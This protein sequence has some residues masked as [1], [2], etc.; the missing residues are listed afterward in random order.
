MKKEK[1]L[2]ACSGGPDSMALLSMYRTR[3]K[4]FVCHINYHKRR[5]AN[6]DE[7]IVKNY[8]KKWNIPFYKYD[9]RSTKKGNFQKLARDFRYECFKKV[10]IK[11]NIEKVYVAHQMDD[12]IETYLMQ[13]N[14]QTTVDCYGISKK[15][16]VNG[17]TIYR[18]LLNKT[19]TQLINYLN[20]NNIEY[21][22]DESNYTDKYERNRVRHNV[23]DKM[24][25][26]DKKTIVNEINDRNSVLF[27]EISA[28]RHFINQSAHYKYSSFINFKYFDRLIRML[29]YKDLSAKNI[30]EIHKALLSKDNVELVIRNKI[31]CKEYGNIYVYDVIKPYSVKIMNNKNKESNYFKISNKGN[32]K[33]GAFVKESDYPLT[34]RTFKN[35]D[36]ILMNYGTK[37]INRFFV[38]N[39]ISSYDRKVWPIVLNKKGQ[40]ILVP[41]LGCDKAH[42]AKK[43]NLYVLKL[44]Y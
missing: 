39:K 38:D 24:S 36:K 42:Y 6:R 37:K 33:E 41:G 34:I 14:R 15:I 27:K 29:L 18:P 10:C 8:C 43:F 12:N 9:Y 21:G 16:L 1:I 22:I 25:Y 11:N 4:V 32:S 28:T 40:I 5:S 26:E 3:Y 13:L 31:I 35:G 20:K 44:S 23:V 2:I 30:N 7:N 19:K 17:I